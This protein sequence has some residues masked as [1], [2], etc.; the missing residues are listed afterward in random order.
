M[1]TMHVE[2]VSAE[3]RLWS[4]EAEMVIARTVDGEIGILPGH[5]PVLAELASSTLRV[6]Q[7]GGEELVAAIHGGFLSVAESGVSVLADIAE[8]AP[9]IDLDRARA[10]YDR[11]SHSLTGD[12]DAEAKAALDRATARIKAA[13]AS[14]S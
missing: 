2:L 7:P 10:A 14:V 4:G 9:D 3:R 5:A 13:G 6:V 11:A 8:L 1:A 12:D